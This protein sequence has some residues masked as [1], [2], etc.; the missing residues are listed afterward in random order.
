[1]GLKQG[2]R[3]GALLESVQTAQLDG[4]IKTREEAIELV[5]SLEPSLQSSAA[6][7]R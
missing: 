2:P 5:K 6:Q 4:E 7:S 3:I 1:M